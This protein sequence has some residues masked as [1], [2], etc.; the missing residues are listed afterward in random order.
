MKYT[1]DTLAWQVT[2]SIEMALLRRR[3]F[4]HL[5]NGRTVYLRYY[6]TEINEQLEPVFVFMDTQTGKQIHYSIELACQITKGLP[7]WLKDFHP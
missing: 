4:P 1:P 5:Y 6:E 2:P 7:N 3:S